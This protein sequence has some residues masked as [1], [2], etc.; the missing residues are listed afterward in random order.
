MTFSLEERTLVGLIADE[1]MVKGFQMTG[2]VYD[3]KNPNFHMVSSTTSD[4]DLEQLFEEL[5]IRPDIA[6]VFVGDFVA[7]RI[8]GCMNRCT[9]LIPTVLEIPTKT[10]GINS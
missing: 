5:I 4:E 2:L 10:G 9:S 7:E 3:K 8:R 6:I 1:G